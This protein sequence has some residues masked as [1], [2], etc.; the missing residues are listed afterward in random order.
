[1]KTKLS[2]F[3]FDFDWRLW[4]CQ[5]KF[6]LLTGFVK[7]AS[8]LGLVLVPL[9]WSSLL[10]RVDPG[11]FSRFSRSVEEF[12]SRRRQSGAWRSD[13][14]CYAAKKPRILWYC[15]VSLILRNIF[16]KFHFQSRVTF[17][18]TELDYIAWFT[19]T[20][21]FFKRSYSFAPAAGV[22]WVSDC[23]LTCCSSQV[24]SSPWNFPR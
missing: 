7:S 23:G 3:D 16:F 9:S 6:A 22:F 5:N 13:N 24:L 4:V 19:S 14:W 11:L 8:T 15:V 2:A 17:S 20:S 10:D 21:S 1:M 18:W 12:W